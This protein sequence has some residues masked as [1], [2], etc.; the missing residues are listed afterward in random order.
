MISPKIFLLT[1]GICLAFGVFSRAD[2]AKEFEVEPLSRYRITFNATADPGAKSDWELR[3]FTKEGFLPHEGVHKSDWQKIRTGSGSYQHDVLSPEKAGVLKLVVN[4]QGKQPEL[5]DLKLEK[6]EGKNLV[7]NGDFAAG[8]GNYSG[9]STRYMAELIP[10]EAGKIVLKC[11]PEGYA[12]TDFIPVQAGAKYRLLPSSTPGG[13]VLLYDHNRL[14]TGLMFETGLQTDKNPLIEIPSGVAYIRIEYCDGRAYSN[15][16]PVVG[17]LG[18]KQEGESPAIAPAELAA[19]PAEIVVAPEAPLQEVRAAREIQHWV[20][21]ISGKSIHV[22][23]A[24]GV[25]DAPKIY[26][27]AQWAQNLFPEDIKQLEGSDGYAVR[28]KGENIYV[29]GARP[30][31]ALHGAIRL[32]E[33]NSDLIFARPNQEI[34]TVFS[35]NPK[36]AFGKADFIQRPAFA[37]RM[38][39][40]R[41]ASNSADGIWQGRLGMNT[42]AYLYNGFRSREMGGSL[43]FEDNFMGVIEENPDTS[44]EKCSKEHPEFYAMIDG[45]RQLRPRGYICYT[46]PGIA[47]ALADGLRKSIER[48]ERGGE[49]LEFV[50]I[51][52][53]DGWAVCSCP[54]CMTPIKLPDGS[55]LEPKAESSQQDPLFFSTR[56][57][58]FVNEV[59]KEMAQTHPDIKITV[60]GYIYASEPPAV[61]HAASLSPDF[62]AYPTATI[63]FPLLEGQ[64]NHHA[65]GREWELKFRE[66]LSRAEKIKGKLCMFAYYYPAGF[67]SVADAAGAD[68]KEMQNVGAAYKI[69]FD[70]WPQDISPANGTNPWDYEAIEKWIMA[71][72]MW[73]PQAHPQE[74]RKQYIQRAYQGAAAEMQEFHDTIRKAWSDPEIKLQV[75]VHTPSSVLFDTFVVK[76]GNEGKLRSLLLSARQKAV[77]PNSK[78]LIERNLAAFDKFAEGMNRTHIPYVEE[79]TM[80]WNNPESTFWLQALKLN[81]FKQVSTWENF[82][83]APAIHPTE[84]AIMRDKD[85]LYV[86]FDA[87]NAADQRDQVELHFE[88]HRNTIKYY[89]SVD[90]NGKP[91]GMRNGS[92]Q[93]NL[94]WLS[95]VVPSVNGYVAMFRIPFSAIENLDV[96]KDV[97]ELPT[98]FGRLV[99][100]DKS[101]EESTLDGL[102]IT[103]TQ[104][105]N[106]WKVLT[107]KKNQ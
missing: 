102:S 49:K 31:G 73:N 96:T 66:F 68:W 39:H 81:E 75:S 23:A 65:V 69:I 22:L 2:I 17:F 25:R 32:L 21:Q 92:P 71:K 86:R 107:I 30:A 85:H 6:L 91:H 20:E 35:K 8:L 37:Y 34:G 1:L 101:P 90:R 4:S 46:A 41:P 97:V 5:S 57:A 58:L 77:N 44:F 19:Y 106:H 13:R 64:N 56:M 94:T 103:T 80:E 51:R 87:Q 45:T 88:A 63:R 29:F 104:F 42:S 61:M 99:G 27:G 67:S 26:V 33:E 43:S 82:M 54:A 7:I 50:N 3:F 89:L 47:K 12:I 53:R 48:K 9:W 18:I 70:G 16:V 52:T 84:V 38:S 72:L 40:L 105:P 55:L 79:S 98:K 10:S 76:P 15:R 60:P 83:S 28:L 74:L 24:P 36:F 95:K 93:K 11:E 100:D 78:A 14:R 62:C 59:A